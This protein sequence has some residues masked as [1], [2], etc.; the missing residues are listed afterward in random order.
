MAKA[1]SWRKNLG[2]HA[3][4]VALDISGFSRHK[5]QPNQL[6]EQRERFFRAVEHTA[7]F[8]QTRRA[9]TVVVHFLGDELRL[10]FKSAVGA[11]E[12][13]GFVHEVMDGLDKENEQVK[14]AW[15]T[16]V[17]GVVL[18]GEVIWKEWRKCS[19]LDGALP[20]KAQ[21]WMETLK[22]GD[23]VVDQ[24]FKTA[25]DADSVPTH[26]FSARDVDSE[27]GYLLR[28]GV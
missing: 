3:Y 23:I 24:D 15:Q 21:Q 13:H 22:A 28:K 8:D 1:S 2:A 14:A 11:G 18:T 4:L 20:F 26:H 16:L 25:L 27:S 6:L 10:A 17:K 12:V 9:K 5:T 7:L 19:F